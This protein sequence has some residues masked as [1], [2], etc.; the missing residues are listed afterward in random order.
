MNL[1]ETLENEIRDAVISRLSPSYNL[2][3][4]AQRRITKSAAKLADRLYEIFQKQERKAGKKADKMED[5][6]QISQN[7]DRGEEEDDLD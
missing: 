2:S 1:K 6:P 3:D 4:K 5:D 7:P